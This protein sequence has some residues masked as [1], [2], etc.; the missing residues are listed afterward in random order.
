MGHVTPKKTWTG[1][2]KKALV[3][4]HEGVGGDISAVFGP[5]GQGFYSNPHT[6]EFPTW[7]KG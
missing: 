7:A 4:F 3:G 2:P 6:S 5:G 1:G